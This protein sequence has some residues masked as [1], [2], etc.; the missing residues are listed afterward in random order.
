MSTNSD[1]AMAVVLDPEYV[2]NVVAAQ[3]AGGTI[4]RKL[5]AAAVKAANIAVTS[6]RLAEW[7]DFL[8]R[9]EN[10]APSIRKL[11]DMAIKAIY[12]IALG[13]E[14]TSKSGI[15]SY[16]VAES[17]CNAEALLT[18]DQKEY[19]RRSVM[20]KHLDAVRTK[21]LRDHKAPDLDSLRDK[22]LDAFAAYVKAGGTLIDFLKEADPESAKALEQT[23]AH[24]AAKAAK[25]AKA[26]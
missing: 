3:R 14:K 17:L 1:H 26:A 7:Q 2:K 11:F 13:E 24:A 5:C 8:Q 4:S 21:I 6:K 12:G 18:A 25:A 16:E 19:E 9:R 22:A 15:I 20:L 23:T 10:A